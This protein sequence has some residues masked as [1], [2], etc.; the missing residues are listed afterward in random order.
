MDS[1]MQTNLVEGL[2]KKFEDCSFVNFECEKESNLY[3]WKRE[4]YRFAKD[5]TDKKSL[6]LIG[7]VGSGKTHLAISIMK[8]LP[9]HE[10]KYK[11]Q[12]PAP[13]KSLFLNADHFFM[14]LNNSFSEGKAKDKIIDDMLMTNDIVCLDDLSKFNFT[15]AKT[16][17]LYYFVN[18][19]YMNERRIIITSNY[20]VQE[21]KDI[22]PR[23]YS[24][25]KEMCLVMVFTN[26]DYRK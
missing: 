4:S 8:E 5:R 12:N 11:Y 10:P 13:A 1:P 6:L 9:N 22:D 20:S 24:R 2:P 25:L 15:P 26:K 21:F 16:E 19:A 17:N 14:K 23:I 18:Q 7:N 3:K